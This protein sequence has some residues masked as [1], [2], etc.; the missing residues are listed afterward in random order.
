MGMALAV[1]RMM[2]P[3]LTCFLRAMSLRLQR[4]TGEGKRCVVAGGLA[5]P[6]ATRGVRH[7]GVRVVP[8][9]GLVEVSSLG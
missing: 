5:S 3:T 9:D 8:P 6:I 7:C 1:L 4:E 2:P